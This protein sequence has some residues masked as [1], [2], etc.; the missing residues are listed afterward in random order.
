MSSDT[1][2]NK[3]KRGRGISKFF[4]QKIFSVINLQQHNS[5]NNEATNNHITDTVEEYVV[6]IAVYFIF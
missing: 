5:N 1:N 3:L 2:A 6:F 4:K